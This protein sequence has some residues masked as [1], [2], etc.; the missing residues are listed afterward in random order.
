MR[1]IVFYG[2]ITLDGYLAA[3]DDNLQ[4]LFD[5]N[6][7]EKTTYQKFFEK[8]DTVVMGRITYQETKQLMKDAPLYP[9]TQTIV[10]SRSNDYSFHDATVKTD[11]PVTYLKQLRETEGGLIWIVGG[12]NFLKP[13]IEA[14]LI[15]EWWIQVAPVL[16]GEG[17]PL[18]EQGD[19]A[20]RLTFV[21]TTTMG[22]LIELHYV[23]NTDEINE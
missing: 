19:Y 13:L 9:G 1:K 14:D 8:V 17:K 15:D 10:F 16:L 12:G 11:D 3:S 18:F 20:K 5:T 21:D 23:R 2:A 6:I 4:W 22:E 7:G